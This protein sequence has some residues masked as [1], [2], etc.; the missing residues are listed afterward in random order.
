MKNISKLTR[1]HLD[2]LLLAGSQE[3]VDDRIPFVLGGKTMRRSDFTAILAKRVEATNKV[4][5]ARAAWLTA[6]HEERA[7]MEETHEIVTMFR[8]I[9]LLMFHS[10][11][12]ALAACG[13]APRRAPRKLTAEEQQQKVERAAATRKARGTL[14][15]RQRE[16]IRAEPDVRETPPPELQ[17][18]RSP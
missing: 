14:G 11:P 6:V 1:T 16:K 4:D 18:C 9:L 5:L 15:R 3:H 12:V 7:L 8:Q 10:N 17:A 13:L 2:A